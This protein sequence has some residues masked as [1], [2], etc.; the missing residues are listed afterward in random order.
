MARTK[1]PLGIRNRN[2]GNLRNPIDPSHTAR[3][4]EGFQVYETFEIGLTELFDLIHVYYAVHGIKTLHGFV[5]RYAPATEN[6][7]QAYIAAVLPWLRLRPSAADTHDLRLDDPWR[8]VDMARAII[9]VECGNPPS[10]WRC[11]LEWFTPE[12]LIVALNNTNC[13]DD[14]KNNYPIFDA[15]AGD[16]E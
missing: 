2:P 3:H 12:M 7:L 1:L 16:A 4:N 15:G 11:G 10:G 8:A 6:D 5:S 14:E 13:W 9:H